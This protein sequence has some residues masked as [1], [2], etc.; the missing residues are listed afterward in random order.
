[1]SEHIVGHQ[2]TPADPDDP[3][4]ARLTGWLAE[5]GLPEGRA[6]YLDVMTVVEDAKGRP[7]AMGNRRAAV[8]VTN[9]PTPTQEAID[10]TQQAAE[11]LR[12]EGGHDE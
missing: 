10:R 4:V 11:E 1:M 9:C 7:I 8:H 6:E 3:D 5:L 12:R 2:H